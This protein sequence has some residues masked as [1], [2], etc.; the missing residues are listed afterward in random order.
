MLQKRSTDSTL[1]AL[2]YNLVAYAC[3]KLVCT[4]TAALVSV[5]RRGTRS[6]QSHFCL[7]QNA[8]QLVPSP[9]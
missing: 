8:D 2:H 9:P 4:G 1:P 7:V 3:P 6:C 5:N